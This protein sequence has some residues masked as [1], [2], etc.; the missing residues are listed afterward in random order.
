MT[1]WEAHSLTV[2]TGGRFELGLGTGRPGLVPDLR[3]L[4]IPVSDGGRVEELPATVDA[5]RGLD[6]D[7]PRTPVVMAV[8][9]PRARALAAE[10]ADTVTIA[11]APTDTREEVAAMVRE[12]RAVRDVEVAVHVAVVGDD[13]AA[14]MASARDTDPADLRARDSLTTLP[15]EPGAAVEELL[16]RREELAATY[17]V[18]GASAAERLAPV[19]ARLAGT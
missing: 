9:G 11:P 5:L 1:A 14:F 3:A 13:I 18:V 2:L 17:A 10:V 6:G 19:I 4:G 7:G 12:V 15:E 16:R 8:R